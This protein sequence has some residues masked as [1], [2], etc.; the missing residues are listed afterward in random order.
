MTFHAIGN[1]HSSFL[2]GQDKIIP[3]GCHNQDKLP[4]FKTWTLGPVIAYNFYEHH[5]PGVL[6]ICEKHIDKNNDY[7]ML[8]VGEVDT[9]W[10]IPFQARKQETSK[11]K[12]AL[13]CFNRYFESLIYLR[14]QGY[15][16]FVWGSH[17]GTNEGHC[18]NLDRPVFGAVEERNKIGLYW[19]MLCSDYAFREGIGYASIFRELLNDDYTTKME[20]MMDYCH[21]SQKALP[22]ALAALEK[23]IIEYKRP[24]V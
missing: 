11:Y 9:R 19:D 10:H 12:V 14:D 15:K 20:Y 16:V 17:P 22:L 7:L 24:L 5:L 6:D 1:S 4:G 21:L 23:G 2:S 13:E 8:M 18:E 3:A